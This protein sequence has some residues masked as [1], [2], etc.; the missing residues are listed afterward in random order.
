MPKAFYKSS[1]LAARFARYS[2]AARRLRRRLTAEGSMGVLRPWPGGRRAAPPGSG[3]VG[4]GAPT[5][6]V[7]PTHLRARRARPPRSVA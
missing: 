1:A 4:D 2:P 5:Q 7:R 3:R 6:Q